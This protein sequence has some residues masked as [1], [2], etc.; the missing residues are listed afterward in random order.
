VE[1]NLGRQLDLIQQSIPVKWHS[2]LQPRYFLAAV[3]A[4][5]MFLIVRRD[6]VLLHPPPDFAQH[7]SSFKWWLVLHDG[8]A[9]ALALFLGPLQFSKRIRKCYPTWHRVAGR[10]YVYGVFVAAPLGAVIEYVKYLHAGGSMRLAVASTGFGLLFIATTGMGFLKIRQRKIQDHRRWM[11][12][13]YAVALI[14]L[15]TRCV[16]Q[17][18]W[19]SRLLDWPSRMFESHSISDLWM[20]ILFAPIAAELVLRGEQL[21]NDRSSRQRSSSEATVG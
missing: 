12:R 16:D 18:P 21:L 5:M 4:L 20:Y 13:S 9:G 10:A 17:T 15:E 2:V 11:T 7:Y 14:F 1:A 8:I 19:L 3:I 6:L